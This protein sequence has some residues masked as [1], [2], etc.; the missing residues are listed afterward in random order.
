MTNQDILAP[1]P[2]GFT[3]VVISREPVE[4]YKVL[5]FE[6]LVG[7]GGEAKTAVAEGLVLLNGEVETQKRKK[8]VAGDT[9]EFGGE[10]LFIVLA[11][12]S[13]AAPSKPIVDKP[14]PVVPPRPPVKRAAITIAKRGKK[15]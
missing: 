11:G 1:I 12:S 3:A 4:L 14:R 15:A 6:G 7:S 8:I 10:K 13:A 2:E 9:I 5:K